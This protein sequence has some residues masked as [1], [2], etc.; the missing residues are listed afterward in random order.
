MLE[1]SHLSLMKQTT[2]RVQAMIHPKTSISISAK[3]YHNGPLEV[4]TSIIEKITTLVCSQIVR[5]PE[6]EVIILFYNLR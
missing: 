2:T 5:N 3:K 6:Y 4:F 1:S